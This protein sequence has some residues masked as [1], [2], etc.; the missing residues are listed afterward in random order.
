MKVA[1]RLPRPVVENGGVWVR[2]KKTTAGQVVSEVMVRPVLMRKV[3]QGIVFAD[4]VLATLAIFDAADEVVVSPP[5]LT[6]E[7]SR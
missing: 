7:E 6:A 1:Q 3:F 2:G 4:D 5:V